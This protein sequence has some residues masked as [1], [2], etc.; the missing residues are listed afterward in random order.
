MNPENESHLESLL[1]QNVFGLTYCFTLTL[2]GDADKGLAVICMH[3]NE[4]ENHLL[5]IVYSNLMYTNY[6]DKQY[7]SVAVW[8]T[9]N[10]HTPE[11]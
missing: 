11:W 7:A 1:D 2:L 10:Q 9:K 4:T 5:A 3:W 6:A 8:S